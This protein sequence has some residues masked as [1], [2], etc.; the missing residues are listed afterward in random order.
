[1]NAMW[2]AEQRRCLE[3]LGFTL[4]RS[5][6]EATADAIATPSIDPLL[7][8]LLRSADR[9]P[10]RIDAQ[11]WMREMQ[12]QSLDA[13]RADPGAKRALWPRLRVARRERSRS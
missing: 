4:Y 13:L 7:R 11:A 5:V 9:D 10:A 1:M 8:A 6:S 2:S 3:A 12:I